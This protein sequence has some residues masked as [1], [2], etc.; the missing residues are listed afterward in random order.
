VTFRAIRVNCDRP[1]PAFVKMSRDRAMIIE[2][3]RVKYRDSEYSDIEIEAF[4]AYFK[5]QTYDRLRSILR[6]M[7]NMRE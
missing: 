5:V 4:M 2:P 3:G 7:T 6:A 1:V